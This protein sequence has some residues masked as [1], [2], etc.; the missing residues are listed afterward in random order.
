MEV[1]ADDCNCRCCCLSAIVRV[2][3]VMNIASTA[4][5]NDEKKDDIGLFQSRPLTTNLV[6]I[7]HRIM[8]VVMFSD[9]EAHKKRNKDVSPWLL[10]RC[11]FNVV[12][13]WS[14]L[15]LMH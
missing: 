8:F 11:R 9:R 1:D 10:V 3:V 4:M 12:E 7:M 14:K 13:T 6:W 5:V 2:N 15:P